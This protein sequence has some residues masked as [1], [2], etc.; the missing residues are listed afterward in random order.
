M[1]L[2]FVD[3]FLFFPFTCITQDHL[4]TVLTFF[5]S[6]EYLS[7][8]RDFKHHQKL[9]TLFK[10]KKILPLFL[11]LKEFETVEL[12]FEQYLSWAQIHKA[13]SKNLNSFLRDAPYF[14]SDSDVTAIKSQ[15]KGINDDKEGSFFDGSSLEQEFLF[16]KMAHVCD[17]Q[18]K[19]IDLNLNGVDQARDKLFSTLHGTEKILHTDKNNK[20]TARHKDLGDLMTRER[21][22]TWSRCVQ[23][24]LKIEQDGCTP[25]FITTSE[26]VFE[27]L[28]SNCR[29][30][31]N[32][33]D[34]DRI[35]VHEN[36]CKNREQWQ[37]DFCNYLMDAI[38]G[39]GN[40]KKDLPQVNDRCSLWGQ[41][42]LSLFSGTDINKIFGL[43]GRQ[44]PVCLI[45]LK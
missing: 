5:P 8:N 39:K 45:K 30:L 37:N 41:I 23:Q 32:S 20:K 25:L 42:K 27:Y 1:T 7:M 3:Q 40:L 4:N 22:L 14:T 9:Q 26:A 11:S 36:E 24:K 12:K 10:Q 16:L 15:I 35:K 17:E 2:K 19:D 13:D 44:I 43:P 28:E 34:I 38:K 21:I 29:N 33:L 6:F 18:N 31:V